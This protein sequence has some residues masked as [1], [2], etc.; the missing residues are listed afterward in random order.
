MQHLGFVEALVEQRSSALVPSSSSK[1]HLLSTSIAGAGCKDEAVCELSSNLFCQTATIT[2]TPPTRTT[3]LMK[4]TFEYFELEA[5]G[6]VSVG[7]LCDVETLPGDSASSDE[8]QVLYASRTTSLADVT[9]SPGY[10]VYGAQPVVSVGFGNGRFSVT[11]V[12]NILART[13][14]KASG[15]QASSVAILVPNSLASS[16]SSVAVSVYLEPPGWSME[17]SSFLPGSATASSLELVVPKSSDAVSVAVYLEP[18]GWSVEKSSFQPSIASSFG[19]VGGFLV[20]GKLIGSLGAGDLQSG[21]HSTKSLVVWKPALAY[22]QIDR[23]NSLVLGDSA[24]TTNDLLAA[25]LLVGIFLELVLLVAI[26]LCRRVARWKQGRTKQGGGRHIRFATNVT[27]REYDRT[28]GMMP[29]KEPSRKRRVVRRSKPFFPLALDWTYV[30]FQADL[31]DFGH[32]PGRRGNRFDSAGMRRQVLLTHGL[33]LQAIEQMD[34]DARRT[35]DTDALLDAE[36]DRDEG[37]GDV[38]R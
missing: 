10:H 33:E 1:G 37:G 6:H 11:A 7:I 21:S 36:I 18:P 9:V 32:S 27:V 30:E 31:E 24:A 22:R 35:F 14:A 12:C 23:S 3:T 19:H 38:A 5:I 4:V 28:V 26:S 17:K 13:M 34:K 25:A 20:R 16:P 8:I 2:L 29:H 15:D